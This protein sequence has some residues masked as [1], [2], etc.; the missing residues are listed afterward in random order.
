MEKSGNQGQA[1]DPLAPP[2]VNEAQA[3]RD[4]S[5]ALFVMRDALSRLSLALKDWQ[6]ENDLNRR[7]NAQCITRNLL[8]R[9]TAPTQ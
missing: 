4:I 7:D 6:F 5:K 1:V 3:L 2:P 9:L 8:A